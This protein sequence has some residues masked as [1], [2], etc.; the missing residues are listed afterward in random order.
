MPHT[1]MELVGRR[2]CTRRRLSSSY[3][4]VKSARIRSQTYV[5]NCQSRGCKGA[6]LKMMYGLWTSLGS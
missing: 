1:M 2:A 4:E 5:P 3:V 6:Q